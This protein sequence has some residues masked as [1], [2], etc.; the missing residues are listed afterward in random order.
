[1]FSPTAGAIATWNAVRRFGAKVT[2]SAGGSVK[3]DPAEN[4]KSE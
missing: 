4:C 3:R 2:G 1:M